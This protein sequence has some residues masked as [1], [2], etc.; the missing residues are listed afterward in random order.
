MIANQSNIV[1]LRGYY[2][3]ESLK[4]SPPPDLSLACVSPYAARAGC[5]RQTCSYREGTRSS[6]RSSRGGT[7]CAPWGT[8]GACSPGRSRGRSAVGRRHLEFQVAGL[9]PGMRR[10]A[11]GRGG[12]KRQA[13]RSTNQRQLT[14]W[15]PGM[16]WEESRQSAAPRGRDGVSNG[17]RE[18]P[19]PA[20]APGGLAGPAWTLL[21]NQLRASLLPQTSLAGKLRNTSP[22]RSAICIPAPARY[23][24][25]AIDRI[26]PTNAFPIIYQGIGER[27]VGYFIFCCMKTC[28]KLPKTPT[29]VAAFLPCKF[30]SSVHPPN[31]TNLLTKKSQYTEI[32]A[33]ISAH[34]IP[35]RCSCS[36]IFKVNTQA[37]SAFIIATAARGQDTG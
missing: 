7:W 27:W 16:V 2:R 12:G 33:P 6:P 15:L 8:S 9:H 25:H 13:K 34:E 26:L 18:E 23:T 29:R 1:S 11:A 31:N 3:K 14:G 19:A 28:L 24:T 21:G 22:D 5:G 10:E 37:C 4:T 35:C 17:R 36:S 32:T 30:S 20:H